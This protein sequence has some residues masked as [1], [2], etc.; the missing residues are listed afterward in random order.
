MNPGI[1]IGVL[2]RRSSLGHFL[3]FRSKRRSETGYSGAPLLVEHTFKHGIDD[4]RVASS[5]E[6]SA[7]LEVSSL[8]SSVDDDRNDMSFRINQH[9]SRRGG[10]RWLQCIRSYLGYLQGKIN[11]KIRDGHS[12]G[13]S[14]GYTH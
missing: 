4:E 7:T 9:F 6:S 10:M 3:S 2:L 13:K 14:Q 8:R 1:L 12:K 5:K 11:E